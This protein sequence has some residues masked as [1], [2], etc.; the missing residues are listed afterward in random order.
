[1]I[2]LSVAIFERFLG[3]SGPPSRRVVLFSRKYD[4]METRYRYSNLQLAC[5]HIC[6]RVLGF[7]HLVYTKS[8]L[9]PPGMA[10]PASENVLSENFLQY[11][12]NP[13]M[14]QCADTYVSKDL[15]TPI[16]KRAQK[17]IR[18]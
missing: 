18:N 11:D 4:Y 9:A 14:A 13:T 8:Q 17:Y 16:A 12:E 10:R 5:I 7:P 1:L 15:R 3:A 2:Y 6:E